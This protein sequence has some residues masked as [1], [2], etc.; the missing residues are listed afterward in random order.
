MEAA[1]FNQG[2]FFKLS[3]WFIGNGCGVVN[4][5]SFEHISHI[6][7]DDENFAQRLFLKNLDLLTNR[8]SG[9]EVTEIVFLPP[10]HSL[11]STSEQP[12]LKDWSMC[13][14][15][16]TLAAMALSLQLEVEFSQASVQPDGSYKLEP[17]SAEDIKASISTVIKELQKDYGI[18]CE[19][20]DRAMI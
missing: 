3:G 15:C 10:A 8:A 16:A 5:A 1:D 7:P 18:F 19:N 9:G 20:K 13:P 2:A 12:D 11:E 17:V 14:E 6:N 4:P